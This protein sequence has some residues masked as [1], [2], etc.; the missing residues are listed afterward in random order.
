MNL[1]VES[2]TGPSALGSLKSDWQIVRARSSAAPFLSWEWMSAWQDH[3]GAGGEPFVLK[4]Y[5]RDDE[6]IGL[7]PLRRVATRAFG[8]A[9]TRFGFLGEGPGGADHLDLIAA[10]DEHEEA[11]RSIVRFLSATGIDIVTLNHLGDGSLT[12]QWLRQ[13]LAGDAKYSEHKGYVCPQVDLSNGWDAVLKQSRRR[14]NFGRRL[15][16]VEEREGFAFRSVT[17]PD[18]LTTAF[19]RFLVLH[20]NRRPGRAS[21]LSG[22]AR[23]VGFHRD[24]IARMSSTG[25][26]R[27]D[28]LW[29]E[30]ECRA[31]IYGFDNART[32]YFYNTGFDTDWTHHS[33]GLVLTGLSIRAAVERGVRTYDF[34]RGD[35]AYKFDWANRT[36]NLVNVT[37]A[38]E[39]KVARLAQGLSD[40]DSL[41]RA[42][43]KMLL[44][45]GIAD[46]ARRIRA[47]ARA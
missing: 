16:R 3:F 11:L 41:A 8:L 18:E 17:E 42:T 45:E 43:A 12:A 28:E 7:L 5:S 29:C 32:F 40:L 36:E 14:S 24:V 25:L 23:L 1:R 38:G 15:R 19:E 39:R 46:I 34:L 22:S 44:P 47:H 13:K 33:V 20:Q 30:G 2:L 27:F 35:E 6:L 37:L 31:S 9:V 4:V 10:P 21:E 26:L